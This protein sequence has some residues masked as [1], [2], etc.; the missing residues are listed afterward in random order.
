MKAPKNEAKAPLHVSHGT[1]CQR[2]SLMDWNTVF[3]IHFV[4][5][6][7]AHQ[8]IVSKYHRTALFI[9][10]IWRKQ[11]RTWMSKEIQ[12]STPSSVKPPP[13]LT[14]AA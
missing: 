1:T 10:N 12:Y 6:I 9:S 11:D 14:I 5:L 3:L 4:E 8:A 7:D 13:S 2:T